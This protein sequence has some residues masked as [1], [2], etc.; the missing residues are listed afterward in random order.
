VS[1][2]GLFVGLLVCGQEQVV[3][4]GTRRRGEV[5]SAVR[6]ST[7]RSARTRFA[8]CQQSRELRMPK[9]RSGE[10]PKASMS[11]PLAC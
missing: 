6:V 4:P 7:K 5:A 9:T 10:M 1:P 8:V 3:E 2:G 11:A